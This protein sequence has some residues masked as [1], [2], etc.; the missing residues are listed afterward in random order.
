MN[1]KR[2]TNKFRHNQHLFT[3]SQ[4]KIQEWSNVAI[5]DK[6]IFLSIIFWLLGVILS[7]SLIAL[8]LSKIPPEIPLFYSHLSGPGL[9][10]PKNYIFLLP[11]GTMS[12]G[13][14][15]FGLSISSYSREKVLSYLLAAGTVI[16]TL[17]TVGSVGNIVHL[18]T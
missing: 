11:A 17:L 5:N 8:F 10:A 3:T 1:F 7:I 16:V 12:I 15:N 6:V 13:V 2:T 4:V 9:L 14:L 18:M